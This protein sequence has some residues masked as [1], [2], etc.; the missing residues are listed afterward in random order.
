MSEYRITVT[1]RD[2]PEGVQVEARGQLGDAGCS[3]SV[4]AHALCAAIKRE[5]EFVQSMAKNA[6]QF[7]SKTL[8]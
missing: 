5:T 3:A 8:H 4:V 7:T 6:G 2:T 1:V